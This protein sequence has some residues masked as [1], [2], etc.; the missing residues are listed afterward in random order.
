MGFSFIGGYSSKEEFSTEL[1]RWCDSYKGPGDV[2]KRTQRQTV[3]L[4]VRTL[5]SKD[6]ELLSQ[7]HEE[8]T[9]L[10]ASSSPSSSSWLMEEI[11]SDSAPQ[12]S[13]VT[14]GALQ[15]EGVKAVANQLKEPVLTGIFRTYEFQHLG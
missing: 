11:M 13:K 1:Q 10:L 2:L 9:K 14:W 4:A 7:L 15:P 8:E 3:D 5:Y 12:P 6:V